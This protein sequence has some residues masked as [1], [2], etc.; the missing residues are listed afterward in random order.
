MLS[1]IDL[2]DAGTLDLGL[3]AYLAA[4]MRSGASLLVGARP[5][6]AGKTAVMCALLNWLP[7]RTVIRPV[8]DSSVLSPALRNP[9]PGAACYLA[10]EIGRGPYLAY[11]W[12][13]DVR[14][15]LELAAQGQIVVSNLHADTHQETVAQVCEEN[16][17]P[18][19]HLD[20]VTLQI[21]L[22]V[23]RGPGWSVRRQVDHVYECSGSHR[24]LIW[25]RAGD[26]RLVRLAESELVSD[27]RERAYAALLTELG[28]M[29]TRRIEDVRRYLLER[30]DA[31]DDRER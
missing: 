1:L 28:Q 30:G 17:V 11:I 22:R 14:A 18:P 5:G 8:V 23:Q 25:E 21:Y 27:A 13:R 2:L 4:A 12:G 10:H 16:G 31:L 7:S 24:R 20:A 9:D 3:A 29:G 6:G 19:A 26:A 15:F